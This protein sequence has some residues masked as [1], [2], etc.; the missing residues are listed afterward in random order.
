MQENNFKKFI[1]V[2]FIGRD[3]PTIGHE[4][5]QRVKV[6]HVISFL[7]LEDKVVSFTLGSLVAYSFYDTG[8]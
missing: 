6:S 4:G 3:S 8:G 7:E 2:E 5:T 1:L